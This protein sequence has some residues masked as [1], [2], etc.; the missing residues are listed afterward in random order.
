MEKLVH[1]SRNAASCRRWRSPWLKRQ[2]KVSLEG[3]VYTRKK[4]PAAARAACP[5]SERQ[6]SCFNA[7]LPIRPGVLYSTS[8]IIVFT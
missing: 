3:M 6:A 8:L 4:A 7:I 2:V 1:P 5:V